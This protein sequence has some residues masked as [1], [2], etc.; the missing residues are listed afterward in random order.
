MSQYSDLAYWQTPDECLAILATQPETACERALYELLRRYSGEDNEAAT[1]AVLQKLLLHPRYQGRKNLSCWLEDVLLGNYAWPTLLAQSEAV[2]ETLHS[3]SCR[4]LGEYGGM[5]LDEDTLEPVV[6][7]LFA[8]ATPQAYDI[9]WSILYWH[10][11]LLARRPDWAQW[12]Q[13]QI[14]SLK[15]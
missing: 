2:L 11:G 15:A 14:T 7:R 12:L 1:R 4:V 8:R 13:T 5:H 10:E 9:I 3:E 6:N